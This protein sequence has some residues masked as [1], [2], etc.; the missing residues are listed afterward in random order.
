MKGAAAFWIFLAVYAV[1]EAWLYDRGHDTFF[2]KHK[3]VVEKQIQLK[4]LAEV[5]GQ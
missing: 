4:R 3:T 5:R 1:C 2:W